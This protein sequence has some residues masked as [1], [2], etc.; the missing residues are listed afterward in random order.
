MPR[1]PANGSN[2][3]KPPPRAS[4]CHWIFTALQRGKQRATPRIATG[5]QTR[6]TDG[7]EGRCAERRQ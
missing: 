4:G 1:E 2:T 3:P 7:A 6:G 5:S